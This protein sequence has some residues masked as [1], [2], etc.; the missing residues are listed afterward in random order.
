MRGANFPDLTRTPLLHTQEGF[1][2]IVLQGVKA[3]KGMA[4]FASVLKPEDTL[5]IRSFIVARAN[6]IKKNPMPGFGPPPPEQ[7]HDEKRK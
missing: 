4:S 3:E 2:Q 7:P 5:A 1:D 6:E